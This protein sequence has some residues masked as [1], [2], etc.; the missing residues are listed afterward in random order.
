MPPPLPQ[1]Y[2][3][4]LEDFQFQYGEGAGRLAL[5]MELL[6][7]AEV[8][9]GQLG[10]YCRHGLQPNKV[11]PDLELLQR[12]LTAIRSLVKEAYNTDRAAKLSARAKDPSRRPSLPEPD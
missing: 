4:K 3:E 10:I 8:S 5:A 12:Q 9:A 6:V 7:D 11:H 2:Q 1:D